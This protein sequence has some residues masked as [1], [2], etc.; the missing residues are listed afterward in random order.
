[1]VSFLHD[2]QDVSPK[3]RKKLLVHG[4]SPPNS[5]SSYWSALSI[6]L[7]SILSNHSVLLLGDFNSP[8]ICWSTLTGQVCKLTFNHNL[9]QLVDIPTH[10][11]G[12]IL[13]LVLSSPSTNVCE[14]TKVSYPVL[15][16]DHFIL[17]F[18]FLST[19][20]N[21]Q[22]HLNNP[23]SKF[24]FTKADFDCLSSYLLDVDF[25][26][27]Y[28][29]TD[30]ARLIAAGYNL[31]LY[32]F[33]PV[34]P[35]LSR[36]LHCLAIRATGLLRQGRVT[37]REIQAHSCCTRALVYSIAVTKRMHCRPHLYV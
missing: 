28:N 15:Q 21:P 6:Y 8:D 3:R 11:S 19:S 32:S 7:D 29:S 23:S 12:N 33:T 27:Y 26:S 5:N 34:V 24:A 31:S 4:T 22:P 17:S 30:I 9:S 2:D 18:K 25:S 37:V 13:D 20:T 10:N 35:C 16:S 36:R 1:M 14:L